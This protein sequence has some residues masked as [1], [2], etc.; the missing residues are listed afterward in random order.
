M[1]NRIMALIDSLGLSEQY[2]SAADFLAAVQDIELIRSERR[3]MML[4]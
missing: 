2:A 4:I 1:D 3:P